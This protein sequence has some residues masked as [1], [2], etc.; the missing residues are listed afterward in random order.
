MSLLW[1]S[2]GPQSNLVIAD[3]DMTTEFLTRRHISLGLNGQGLNIQ[4]E[5]AFRGELD[6]GARA[7]VNRI[8]NQIDHKSLGVDVKLNS[9]PGLTGLAQWLGEAL[10]R[11]G[12]SDLCRVRL[13]AGN[14][15]AVLWTSV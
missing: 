7:L 14:G 2:S 8:L 9:A 11:E 1:A 3:V 13:E 5:L 10:I 12:L 4:A 15:S 6:P